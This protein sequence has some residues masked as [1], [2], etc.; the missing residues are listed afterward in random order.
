MLVDATSA[1]SRVPYVP[2]TKPKLVHPWQREDAVRLKRL[3][4]ERRPEGMSQETF[5]DE[6][7]IGSQGMVWQY[8][9]GERPLN[10]EAAAK[11]ARGLKCTIDD[12]SPTI[13]AFLRSEIIP[14]LGER[15]E[16]P[17][18]TD[19]RYEPLTPDDDDLLQIYRKLRELDL[20]DLLLAT[21]RTFLENAMRGRTGAE[22]IAIMRPRGRK[23]R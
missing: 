5:G 22:V 14:V 23:P 7:E 8:I 18:G 11:F 20:G 15:G 13:A 3:Y 10:I 12:I 2:K 1:A 16:L 21:A 19:R 9:S 4:D 17:S 6:Y